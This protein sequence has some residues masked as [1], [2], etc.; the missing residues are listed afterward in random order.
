MESLKHYSRRVAVGIA[1]GVVLVAGVVMIPYP[2]PG[3]LVVF[4]GL[5]ILA[6]EF[7][8]ARAVLDYAKGKYDAWQLWVARQPTWFKV[9]I[10]LMTAAIVLVTVWFVNGYGLINQWLHLDQDWLQ[11]PIVG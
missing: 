11:S 10:W 6:T 8:W 9:L 1:G 5:G 2:G 7:E 3:W 4:V